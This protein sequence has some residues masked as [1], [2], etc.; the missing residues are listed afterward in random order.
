M[1]A[2]A[3]AIAPVVEVTYNGRD[4]T[5]DLSPYLTRW[6]FVDRMTG[7]ADTLD[8][9]L[10]ESAAGATRWLDEWYPDKGMEI[11]A[12]FGWSHQDL[13][14]TGAFDV[15][16]IAVDSPPLVI[17]IRAQSA[18]VSRAVRTR[19][20]RAYE[21]TTLSGILGQIAQRLGAR[22]AGSIDPDPAIERATQYQ[23]TDWQF[24][25]RLAREYGY[26]VKLA[27]NNR[28]LAVARLADDQ[29]PVRTL[30]VADLTRLSYRDQIT[31]VPGR[32]TIRHH[33]EHTGQ[34]V[35]Y[36]VDAR[37][38]VVPV[39]AASSDE[40]KR[41]VR[42]RSAED[43][44]ARAR[45]E[46]ERHALDKTSLEVELPGDPRLAA[47]LA[48][49]MTG[50]GRLKGRYVIVEARHDISRAGFT[51]ALQLKRIGDGS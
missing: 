26:V 30:S 6:C 22:L 48:V 16:E 43:A 41:H 27:D 10:G 42:A 49:D 29:P 35:V 9:E 38:Q 33:D 51:T 36:G 2:R 34:L 4:I 40:R 3:R 46:A 31:D 32:V 12:R 20:G 17:R 45:A 21:N 23:E 13:V 8:I 14:P 47:G 25:V 18:G 11:S 28:A 24:A 7:E 37:G 1:D 15:D 44:E 50:P 39:D 19:I 5:A